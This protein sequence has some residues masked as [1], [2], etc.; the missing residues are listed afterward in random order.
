MYILTLKAAILAEEEPTTIANEVIFYTST[1][2]PLS[3]LYTRG[4]GAYKSIM[5]VIDHGVHQ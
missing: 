2:H 5:R 1:M 3:S 4:S